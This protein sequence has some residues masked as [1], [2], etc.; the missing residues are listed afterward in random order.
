MA[1]DPDGI[2]QEWVE[3]RILD[4]LPFKL[5]LHGPAPEPAPFVPGVYLF[6]LG[7]G[8]SFGVEKVEHYLADAGELARL[9][10]TLQAAG[11]SVISKEWRRKQ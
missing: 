6:R 1:R 8:S 11:W 5:P 4:G 3:E 7:D 10:A 9:V 2:Y